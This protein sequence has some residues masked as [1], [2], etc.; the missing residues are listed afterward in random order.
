M[1]NRNVT[2]VGMLALAVGVL[3]FEWDIGFTAIG[4]GIVLTMLSPRLSKVA[5]AKVAWQTVLL[6]CGVVTYVS[7]LE[8][9]GTVEWLGDKVADM[10]APLFAALLICYIGGVVSAFASTTGILGTLIR[11]PGRSCSPARWGPSA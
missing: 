10:D 2:V 4:L 7:L 11:W 8:N 1:R 5:V 3:F 9:I 6:I